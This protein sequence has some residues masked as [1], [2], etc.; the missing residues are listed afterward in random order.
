MNRSL[1]TL[2]I[3]VLFE[4]QAAAYHLEYSNNRFVSLSEILIDEWMN[5]IAVKVKVVGVCIV[6]IEKI[7][8]N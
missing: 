3:Y 5:N 1:Q 6:N 8:G 2:L 4:Q 7:S